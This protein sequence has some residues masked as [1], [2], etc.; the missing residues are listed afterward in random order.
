MVKKA[1][2]DVLYVTCSLCGDQV[3]IDELELHHRTVHWS[4][5]VSVKQV[6]EALDRC[7]KEALEFLRARE[8][9]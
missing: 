1:A 8:R 3:K 9:E 7:Y 4:K 5:P 2:A 6:V